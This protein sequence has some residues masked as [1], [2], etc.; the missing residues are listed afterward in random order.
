MA[1][2]N[3]FRWLFDDIEDSTWVEE[4]IGEEA[5]ECWV[6]ELKEDMMGMSHK[7]CAQ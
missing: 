5:L 3:E 6:E 4:A 7:V 1:I 2:S